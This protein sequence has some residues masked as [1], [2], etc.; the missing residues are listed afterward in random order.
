MNV[1]VQDNHDALRGVMQRSLFCL[2]I[3]GDTASSR[4]LT[5]IVLAGCIPVFV[6]PPWHSMPLAAWLDYSKF[7]LFVE[8]GQLV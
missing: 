1:L 2:V 8:L 6:G 3:P 7:A 4:R 5:E